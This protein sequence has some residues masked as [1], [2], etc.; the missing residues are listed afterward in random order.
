M[1]NIKVADLANGI[2]SQV[3]VDSFIR[4]LSTAELT[5]QGGK[6]RKPTPTPTVVPDIPFVLPDISTLDLSNIL[7]GFAPYSIF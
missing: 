4:E 3:G 7:V 1:A 6:K 5:L 2:T